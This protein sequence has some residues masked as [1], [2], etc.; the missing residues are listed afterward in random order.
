M[1]P[2]ATNRV[3]RT[4]LDTLSAIAKTITDEPFKTVLGVA[5]H[6]LLG[7]IDLRADRLPQAE[8]HFRMAMKLEDEM[9]YTEPPDW[10]YPDSPFSGAV[11]SCAP[12]KQPNAEK[13]LSRRSEAIPGQ[14]L[15]AVRTGQSLR[16]KESGGSCTVVAR[17]RAAWA[18]GR[19]NTQRFA[20]LADSV[21]VSGGVGGCDGD[22]G[23]R[24]VSGG[25]GGCGGAGGFDYDL[26][27][28]SA[29]HPPVHLFFLRGAC[30][31]GDTCVVPQ[32]SIVPPEGPMFAARKLGIVA[33]VIAV[34][35][36]GAFLAQGQGDS[37]QVR[38][39]YIAADEVIWDYAPSGMDKISGQPFNEEQKPFAEAGPFTIGHKVKK[40]IYREYTDSTFSQLKPRPPEWEHLGMLGPLVRAVVGD[41]IRIVFKNN[42]KLSLSVHRTACSTTRTPKARPTRTRRPAETRR[43]TVFHRV[44][45][46][47]IPGPCRSAQARVRASR[48][49]H[50]GCTTHTPKKFVM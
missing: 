13:D 18:Q 29:L 17:L 3:A 38:T 24:A 14:R 48:A 44:V 6:A 20:L 16:A 7:E 8:Q 39:Y 15:V 40:A 32:Q 37:P 35:G 25:A 1:R 46:T 41:T 34:L 47:S 19:R 31:P 5:Q 10:Y 50:S 30:R 42:T 36:V 12:A 21:A 49:R 33:I 43:T 9:N 23:S 2:K 27:S 22:G 26:R 28:A 45:S 4:H 11:R